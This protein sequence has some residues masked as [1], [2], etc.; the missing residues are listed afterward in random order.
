MKQKILGAQIHVS[1]MA[2]LAATMQLFVV[3]SFAAA[4]PLEERPAV[5]KATLYDL[6]AHRKNPM[7]YYV[8]TESS[9]HGDKNVDA[10]F[11]DPQGKVAVSEKLT[12]VAGKP[13]RYEYEQSQNKESG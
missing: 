1:T 9:S 12:F 2:V 8:R 5:F 3:P 13:Q 4:P 10:V 7:F 11:K 6:D